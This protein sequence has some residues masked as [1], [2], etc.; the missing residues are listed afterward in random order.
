[1]LKLFARTSKGND[2]I[3]VP[4]C[5]EEVT[6][7]QFQRMLKEW[8]GEDWIKLFSIFSGKDYAGIAASK[9]YKLESTLYASVR[10]VME[11]PMDLEK[12]PMPG[13]LVVSG[14]TVIV[15]KH[16]G[17]LSIGQA[18][19]VRKAL[20]AAKDIRECISIAVAVYLQPILDNSEF[21]YARALEVDKDI[22]KM[23]IVK[24]FP[25]GFFL[26]MKLRGSGNLLT[27]AW[28]LIRRK[29]TQ[30]VKKS[31]AWLR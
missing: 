8:D 27:I 20:E 30:N 6:V 13:F 9:D 3:T 25:V 17:R 10:F 24:I 5:W 12:I 1:M 29:V 15:P 4:V 18:I 7:D 26:L 23:P 21:D 11:Q 22:L 31:P 16:I 14:K 2:N 28:N 19:Q